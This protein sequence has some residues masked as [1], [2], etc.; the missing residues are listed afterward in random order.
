MIA[1]DT[2]SLHFEAIVTLLFGLKMVPSAKMSP[3]RGWKKQIIFPFAKMKERTSAP[4]TKF[5][6]FASVNHGYFILASQAFSFVAQSE[7]KANFGPSKG[8]SLW[9]NCV[10]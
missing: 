6:F 9:L 1:L 2:L 3:Y 10:C 4:A 5:F 7:T 8:S